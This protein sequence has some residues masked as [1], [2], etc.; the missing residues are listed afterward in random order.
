M[1]CLRLYYIC[2]CPI[3]CVRFLFDL[4]VFIFDLFVVIFVFIFVCFIVLDI[5]TIT[6]RDDGNDVSISNFALTET[7]PAD[8]T[9]TLDI[10]QKAVGEIFPL[11]TGTQ[12]VPSVGG[13]TKGRP[14]HMRVFAYNEVGFGYSQKSVHPEKPMVIPGAPTAVTL[15]VVSSYQLRV[16]F[17]PPDDTGGDTVTRYIVQ[18]SASPLF[19]VVSSTDFMELSGGAPFRQTLGSLSDPL[20]QGGDY[21]VKVSCCNSQGCSAFPQASSPP[22]LN[23][24]ET[25]SAPTNVILGV[26]SQS[27]LT[28][29]FFAPA[30]DGGDKVTSYMVEWDTSP[31]FNS[32]DLPPNKDSFEVQDATTQNSYTIVSLTESR[33]Y[34]V[35]VTAKNS[36]GAGNSQAASP[37]FAVPEAKVPGTPHSLL[38]TTGAETGKLYVS[39]QRPFV[40]NHRIPCYGT[41]ATPIQCPD[42]S[43]MGDYASDGGA[44]INQYRVQYIQT[45]DYSS[46][47]S[48]NSWVDANHEI[49][50]DSFAAEC[51]TSL[52]PSDGLAA[53]AEYYVRVQ[54]YNSKGYGSV[55]SRGGIYCPS[56][57]DLVHAKAKAA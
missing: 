38:A 25:P 45:S 4:L 3:C 20:V 10:E 12:T 21:W 32:L 15:E 23:P 48:D 17:N 51:S 24:H 50:C 35:K 6:F 9:W 7:L 2:L 57:G 37:S 30:N 19:D 41:L 31:E 53:G 36:A 43:G 34:F 8:S 26:T 40:P 5:R 42:W 28:V 22:F 47:S 13:L 16:F 18:W 46:I 11:C 56:D 54:A 33:M 55:C 29:S 49:V 52:G 1:L 39:W 27:M 44:A 14:Y